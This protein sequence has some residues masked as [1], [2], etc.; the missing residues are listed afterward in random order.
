[1]NSWQQALKQEPN[2]SAL[3]QH[4]TKPPVSA[5]ALTGG[6]TNQCWKITTD[7]GKHF[8]WRPYSASTAQLSLN[9]T[10]EYQ[11]LHALQ[12][13]T[14]SPKVEC[15]LEQGLLLEW[16]E[17]ENLN[18]ASHDES[19]R[20]VMHS[21]AKLHL[22]SIPDTSYLASINT[23]DYQACIEGY[24]QQLPPHQ[25]TSLQRQ[26]LD[27][28]SSKV[29]VLYAR[30]LAFAPQCLCH[31]DLGIYNMIQQPDSSVVVIDWEYAALSTPIVDL[32]TSV[33]AGQFDVLKSVESYASHQDIDKKQW[34]N[35]VNQWIPYLRFMAMLWHQLALNLHA[36]Q[37]DKDAIKI[38]NHQLE[39]DGY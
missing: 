14:F 38:L 19:Q 7:C 25:R 13:A 1:M 24:W 2:L 22:Y 17:G 5:I 26:R 9:R 8:V 33:L 4:L 15:L 36:R 12:A 35:L 10:D 6:L 3:L 16:V 34:F 11:I 18:C 31:F 30:S 27:Y 39:L 20:H 29:N 23:F 32:A 37:S 21:L 28:F